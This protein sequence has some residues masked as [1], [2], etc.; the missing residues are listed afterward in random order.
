MGAPVTLAAIAEAPFALLANAWYDLTR[1]T[2][3]EVMMQT[4]SSST[5][6]AIVDACNRALGT[7]YVFGAEAKLDD[8]APKAF[9]CSEL[10]QWA[11]AQAGLQLV[12]GSKAQAK[13][14]TSIGPEGLLPGDLIFKSKDGTLDQVYHV[15]VFVGEGSMIEAPATGYLVRVSTL[16]QSGAKYQVIYGRPL[17]LVGR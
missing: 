15:G 17:C 10:A 5:R 7:P 8:P 16:W 4:G 9:D 14:C 11:Y 1:R 3:F 6:A 2:T 13:S 12:D